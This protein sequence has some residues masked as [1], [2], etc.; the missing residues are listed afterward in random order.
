MK[1]GVMI[2]AQE[3]VGWPEWKNITQWTEDLGFESLWRSDHFF[4]FGAQRRQARRAGEL[5]GA[6][7]HGQPHVAHPLWAAGAVD[8]LPS[9]GDHGTDGRRGGL[10]FRTAASSSASA[11]AG[12]CPSTRRSAS[13]C[14]RR[15]RVYRRWKTAST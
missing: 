14:R 3:G 12:T 9:P 11:P 5:R 6:D 7:I 10:S 13:S 8:D 1:L 2:E 4:S 15:G